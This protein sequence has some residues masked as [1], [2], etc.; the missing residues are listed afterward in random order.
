MKQS[1]N[2]PTYKQSSDIQQRFQRN[3]TLNSI[4]YALGEI[5][6]TPTHTMLS[7]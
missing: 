7:N 4:E 6:Q 2:S 3:S 1:R 5:K